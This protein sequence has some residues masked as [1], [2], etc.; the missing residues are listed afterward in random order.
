MVARVPL[1]LAAPQVPRAVRA[2]LAAP[3]G[4]DALAN[5]AK[6]ATPVTREILDPPVPLDVLEPPDNVRPP[7][8]LATQVILALRAPLVEEAHPDLPASQVIPVVP[9]LRAP[10]AE[11][12][13]LA[14]PATPATLAQ[15]A[16]QAELAE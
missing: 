9:A 4:L 6:L 1:V 13:R 10:W 16:Q 2:T 3:A 5:V 15:Q 11:E 12:A 14:L 7:A 8:I